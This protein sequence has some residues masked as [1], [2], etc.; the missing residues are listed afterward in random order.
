MYIS[1]GVHVCSPLLHCSLSLVQWHG[2][3]YWSPYAAISAGG[4]EG[5]K[6]WRLCSQDPKS[7]AEIQVRT[8]LFPTQAERLVFYI[9]AQEK[10]VFIRTGW[11]FHFL[12][13]TCYVLWRASLLCFKPNNVNKVLLT[14]SEVLHFSQTIQ[15]IYIIVWSPFKA[16]LLVH[17]CSGVHARWKTILV[18]T[19]HNHMV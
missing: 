1:C 17:A 12:W 5:E 14:F 13:C 9:W 6:V 16:L 7:L 2:L 4:A 11:K 15:Q 18:C 3:L 8:I 19:Q 10:T